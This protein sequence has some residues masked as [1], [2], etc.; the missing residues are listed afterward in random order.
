MTSACVQ[1]TANVGEGTQVVQD[2]YMYTALATDIPHCYLCSL[3]ELIRNLLAFAALYIRL[4]LQTCCNEGANT[5]AYHASRPSYILVLRDD[6][7]STVPKLTK[8]R[9]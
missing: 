4:L 7:K 6:R 3:H 2:H 8:Q 1:N 9:N 5:G